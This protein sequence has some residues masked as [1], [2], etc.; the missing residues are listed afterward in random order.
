MKTSSENGW[1]LRRHILKGHIS[2]FSSCFVSWIFVFGCH[3]KTKF[4]ARWTFSF[5]PF[6]INSVPSVSESRHT[7]SSEKN[8]ESKWNYFS[9]ANQVNIIADISHTFEIIMTES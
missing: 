4:W 2:L 6:Y 7:F 5:A 9:C 1:W 3:V 8:L